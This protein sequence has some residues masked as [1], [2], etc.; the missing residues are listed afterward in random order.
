MR[1]IVLLLALVTLT[2]APQRRVTAEDFEIGQL[3]SRIW[4]TVDQVSPAVVSVMG[5]GSAFSGVIVSPEGLVLSAGHT[6]EPGAR[7]RV[8]LPDGRTFVAE[9]LGASRKLDCGM[10]KIS[11]A[12]ELPLARIGNSSGVLTN[13]PCLGLSYPGGTQ[14]RRQPLVRFGRI[15]RPRATGGMIQSTALME[16]GDSGGALFDLNGNLIAIHSR[17]GRSMDRNYDVPID[18]FKEHWGELNQ[19][20][21]FADGPPLPRLGFEGEETENRDGVAIVSLVDDG[22]ARQSGLQINDVIT[23]IQDEDIK[24]IRGIRSQL[25]V[26]RDQGLEQLKLTVRRKGKLTNV[27]MPIGVPK[28]GSTGAAARLQTPDTPRPRAIAEL[29]RLPAQFSDIESGL[30]DHCVTVSS[31]LAG[32]TVRILATRLAASRD[33]VSKSSMV[34]ADPVMTVDGQFLTLTIVAR[35]PANDLVLLR[36]PVP[37]PDGVDLSGSPAGQPAIGRFLLTPDPDGMGWISVCSASEFV[38]GKR[39]SKGYLG[40]MLDA[41]ADGNGAALKQVRQGA[42]QE[43]GL[44]SGDVIVRMN[45]TTISDRADL[46][47]FL[48]G[49]DP[50]TRVTAIVQRGDEKLEK[51]I[52]LG[53]PPTGSGHAAD[54]MAKSGRRDG[55]SKVISHDADL[56]PDECGG[57]LYDLNGQFI[58]LNIARYSRVRSY[59]IPRRIVNSFVQQYQ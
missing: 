35:D 21:F 42:A 29:M 48:S 55:F 57:P 19:P 17:I 30:D 47:R 3:Q 9:G 43:A 40:V 51:Q 45:D 1:T 50:Y 7:Y 44:E 27:T 46:L 6:V 59:A 34:G 41:G 58:G 16:P 52:T 23:A 26:A 38:S 18:T 56:P 4:A 31:R 32:K 33:L 11:D 53:P 13:Q 10:L 20:E 8:L 2:V 12:R 28:N 14:N 36:A 37:N 39:E 15:V 49:V 25:M 22:L 54:L 5:R 24:S